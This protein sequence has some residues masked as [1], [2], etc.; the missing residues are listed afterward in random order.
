MRELCRLLNIQQNISTAYHPWMDGQSEQNNQ[1]VETYLQFIVNHQQ[2]NWVE[3][4][5]LAKFTHNNWKSKTTR[6]YPF[7]LLM[8]YHPHADWNRA[9]SDLPLA[10][11]H[12]DQL[13]KIR[14]EAQHH[15]TRAQTL[16][17]EHRTTPKYKEGDQPWLKGRNLHTEQPTA[18]LAP[19]RHGPFMIKQVMS[20]ASYCLNLPLQ[21]KIHPVFH[22]D[23]LTPYHK[24]EVHGVNYQC[25]PPELIDKKEEYKV[26]AILDLRRTGRGCKLQYLIKWKGYSNANNQWEDY[27]NVTAD[28]LV[29][30]FQQHNP[31]KEVHSR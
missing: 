3:Y 12:L 27:K 10:S 22:I 6:E 5:L 2:D 18:K 31:T 26:E 16:W 30:Q 9:I 24:T 25:P 28:N 17:I 8:G 21:W 4:L 7:F 11:K 29:C 14:D 23:L 15:M 19:Q 20:P 13:A 1:W